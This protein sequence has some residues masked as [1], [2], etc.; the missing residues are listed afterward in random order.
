MLHGC[1]GYSLP[2]ASGRP[3]ADRRAG[4]AGRR[5]LYRSYLIAGR[6]ERG[7]RA[8]G[9]GRRDA[10]LFPIPT[11]F[12]LGGDGL[13]SWL[14]GPD[15]GTTSFR[16]TVF[17]YG[18]R[19]VVR[20]VAGGLTRSGSVDGYVCGGAVARRNRG[21]LPAG[22]GSIA[23]SEWLGFSRCRLRQFRDGRAS[24]SAS[25][26]LDGPGPWHLPPPGSGS[27]RADRQ[28]HAS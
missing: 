16:R 22:R 24:R 25:C 1:C 13:R 23:R 27:R 9:S 2:Q 15:A 19:N 21:S 10:R 11:A 20:A 28:A 8:G 18:H 12:R 14:H 26:D 17:T 5:P 4:L 7:K 3:V 6:D